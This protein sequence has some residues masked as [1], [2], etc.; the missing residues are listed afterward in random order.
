LRNFNFNFKI[1]YTTNFKPNT[2]VDLNKIIVEKNFKNFKKIGHFIKCKN[3]IVF[4]ILLR[5]LNSSNKIKFFVKPAFS[6][7]ITL[8]RAPYK[9]KI[10][11][12]QLSVS[13]YFILITFS[14]NNELP[15]PLLNLNQLIYLNKEFL[16]FMLFFETNIIY[17]HQ[18]KIF[19][20]FNFKNFFF[21]KNYK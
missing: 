17:K 21:I 19:A 13:R 3:F 10:S 6:N 20:F 14:L 7:T 9:N 8:L 12:H 11:R 18:I 4:I 1:T 16:N 2:F 15:L 5:Y